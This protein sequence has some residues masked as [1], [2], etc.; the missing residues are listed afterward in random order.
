M[1]SSI[2]GQTGFLGRSKTVSRTQALLGLSLQ[3]HKDIAEAVGH[4]EDRTYS[5]TMLDFIAKVL[6]TRHTAVSSFQLRELRA[7]LEQ[8]EVGQKGLFEEVSTKRMEDL[9]SNGHVS[10]V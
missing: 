7:C 4:P 3:G 6:P 10:G 9:L 2:I 5:L 1:P 8:Q